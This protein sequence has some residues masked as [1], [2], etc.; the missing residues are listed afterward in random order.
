M[1][2]LQT[3]LTDPALAYYYGQKAMRQP[4]VRRALGDMVSRLGPRPLPAGDAL[5]QRAVHDLQRDGFAPLPEKT[6]GAA[7]LAAIHAHYD[8]CLATDNYNPA[9]SFQP[10][11]QVPSSC[12]RAAYAFVD[13]LACMP[14]MRLAND[15]QVLAAVGQRLGCQPTLAS[16]E[17]W[18]TFGENNPQGQPGADDIFHRDVDDLR[19]VKLFVYLTDTRIDN[20]AHCYVLK[21]HHSELLT[22]RGPITD[23]EVQQAFDGKDI[24][25]VTGPAG[26][27]F[28]EETWGIHRPLMA[29]SGRRLIFSA[30]YTV[31]G[32]LPATRRSALPLPAGFDPYI[33]R[34]LYTGATA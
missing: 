3:L 18:W 27:A 9:L 31:R 32:R 29:R 30:I 11:R 10:S 2:L 6:L 1:K 14:L 21:S 25:T 33:N 20:G 34:Y 4:A 26:T 12:K 28:L 23:A 7:A 24:L 13:T 19:F 17:S 8:G 22:R 5:V 15:A 16:V